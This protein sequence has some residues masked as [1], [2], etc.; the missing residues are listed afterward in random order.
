MVTCQPTKMVTTRP[1]DPAGVRRL[2][3]PVH[4]RDDATPAPGDLEP[5]RSFLSLHDHA[6]DVEGGL[7]PSPESL[8]WWLTAS[9]F[10]GPRDRVTDSDLR[11]AADVRA[12]LVSGVREHTG[13]PRDDRAVAV[14]NDAVERTGLALRFGEPS[15]L[16]VA[17]EA[18]GVRGA[19]GTLLRSAF[20]AEL[21][22]RWERFRICGDPGCGTVF[23]DRS[24]NR[25]GRW[26]SM[27]T[28]GNRAKVR[29]FRRRHATT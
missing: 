16:P 10:V 24:R 23:Y 17:V 22:G 7:D 4:E 27:A 21:D 14:L 3:Q 1:R 25:S 8:R 12:A 6:P 13:E 5:L 26:C 11:W 29:A 15:G 18:Q 20:L 2:P 19:I 9:G 28:C